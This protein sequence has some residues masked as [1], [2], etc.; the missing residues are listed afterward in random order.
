VTAPA[1]T[2]HVAMPQTAGDDVWRSL[3]GPQL[4]AA[5][6]AAADGARLRRLW[7]AE[8]VDAGRLWPAATTALDAALSTQARV[9]LH[10]RRQ[11]R[12]MEHAHLRAVRAGSTASFADRFP[13]PSAPTLDWA[14][15]ADR[16]AGVPA[17]VEVVIRPIELFGERPQAIASDLLRIAGIVGVIPAPASP[18]PTYNERGIRVARA[19]NAHLT[20]DPER[21]LVREFV[22]AHFAGPVAGNQFLGADKRG[23]VLAGYAESNRKFFRAWLPEGSEDAY[24]DDVRTTALEGSLDRVPG[25]KAGG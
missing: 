13:D 15:L 18:T 6:V 24:C 11:D 16:I 20:T 7:V 9:V 1:L 21:E 23:G 5:G 4:A 10:V 8:A 22:A 17:V 2:V 14:E 3:A 25:G 12:F 19:M